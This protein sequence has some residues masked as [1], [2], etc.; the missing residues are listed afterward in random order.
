MKPMTLATE[1][2]RLDASCGTAPKSRPPVWVSQQHSHTPAC[3]DC[4][5]PEA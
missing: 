4:A 1:E 5:L 2:R 3:L